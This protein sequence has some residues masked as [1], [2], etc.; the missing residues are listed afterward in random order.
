MPSAA[1]PRANS[2]IPALSE[3]LM[4]ARL[5]FTAASRL[6][7]Q[8][9]DLLAQRVAIDSEHGC[10]GALVALRLAEHGLDQRPLDV[11][12][13]HVVDLGRLLAVHVAEI[14]LERALDRIGELVIAAHCA[15]PSK[16]APTAAS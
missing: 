7:P 15:S 12:E 4:S 16:N 8:L 5:T 9:L 11:P 10:R 3:T 6:D 13:H 2:T 14:A 1:S